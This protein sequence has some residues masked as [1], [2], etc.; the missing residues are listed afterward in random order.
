MTDFNPRF[1][2]EVNLTLVGQKGDEQNANTLSERISILLHLEGEI[3]N[4]A[5]HA[6]CQVIWVKEQENTYD[7]FVGYEVSMVEDLPQ[8][9]MVYKVKSE[10]MAVFEHLGDTKSI[11]GFIMNIYEDWLPGSGYLLNNTDFNHMQYVSPVEDTDQL[12]PSSERIFKWEVR[13]PVERNQL[14]IVR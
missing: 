8:E 14:K 6:L 9:L 2:D 11:A 10:K 5:N 3:K 7:I 1:I 12:L 4:V 13:I